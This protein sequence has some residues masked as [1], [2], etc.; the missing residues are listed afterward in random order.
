M[1]RQDILFPSKIGIFSY[2][3]SGILIQDEKVLLQHVINDPAYAFPGGHVNF[4]EVSQDALIREFKEEISV[5]IKPE[6]LLWVGENFFPWG[7]KDC[8]QICL[9]YL[10]RLSDDHQI[11]IEGCFLAQDEFLGKK[12]NLE[13]CWFSLKSIEKVD[14]YPT[15]CKEMLKNL[16][17][18]VEIF[19]YKEYQ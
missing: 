16:S 6:R 10:V 1:Q 14:L 8:H 9:Y 19:V 5:E 12:I 2:R 13:F 3:V 17:D 11:P 15:L 18:Q 7:E 4:G